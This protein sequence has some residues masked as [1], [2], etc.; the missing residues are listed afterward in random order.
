MKIRV[1]RLLEYTYDTLEEMENDMGRWGVAANGSHRIG[2]NS[3][4]RSAILPSS[5]MDDPPLPATALDF[6]GA[7]TPGW[8][9]CSDEG[10]PC[11]RDECRTGG[12]LNRRGLG[13]CDPEPMPVPRNPEAEVIGAL[14]GA[15]D[16]D[17]ATGNY[18]VAAPLAEDRRARVYL[19]DGDDEA[20]VI[21]Q[22]ERTKS[23]N[24]L[25]YVIVDM[26]MATDPKS[27][28]S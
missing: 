12:C 16:I 24:G 14:S 22:A 4:I 20:M 21:R 11:T 6:P 19:R 15:G 9:G 10:Y 8:T 28:A 17:P 7:P 27:S 23:T 3:T 26:R 2:K 13:E 1:L 18:K 25:D 5:I